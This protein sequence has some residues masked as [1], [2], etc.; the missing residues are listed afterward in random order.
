M[1]EFTTWESYFYPETFNPVTRD[2]TLVNLYEERDADVLRTLEYGDTADRLR[3]LEKDPGKIPHTYDL[4]HL[5]AIHGYV[6]QDVYPWAG[7]LRTVNMTTGDT[8]FANIN[9]GSWGQR[10]TAERYIEDAAA[11]VR[12][13]RWT[14]LDREEFG[15]KIAGVFAHVNQAHPFREGNGRTTKRFLDHVAEQSR[16]QLD[17]T[18]VSAEVWNQSSWLTIPDAGAYEVH[19]EMIQH[20]FTAI[21]TERPA[22]AVPSQED[23]GRAQQRSPYAPAADAVKYQNRP[24]TQRPY[25]PPRAGYEHGR[26]GA[27]R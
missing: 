24:S 25:E 14:E 5:K 15:A 6:F 8:F 9:R 16:F 2:G 26:G 22:P 11:A 21:A 23:P 17:Y 7:Q 3:E 27:E 10:S 4:E 18:R 12:T 20:V 13:T 19:P 1:A